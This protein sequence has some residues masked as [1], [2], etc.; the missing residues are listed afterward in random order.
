MSNTVKPKDNDTISSHMVAVP[1]GERLYLATLELSEQLFQMESNHDNLKNVHDEIRFYPVVAWEYRTSWWGRRNP[2][3]C[4]EVSPVILCG[5]DTGSP[6]PVVV[7]IRDRHPFDNEVLGV[8]VISDSELTE[9]G[10]DIAIDDAR[11]PKSL[12][13]SNAYKEALKRLEGYKNQL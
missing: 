5:L 4:P 10:I 1:L 2:E 3:E 12:T 13:R 9:Y 6:D 7:R 11:L 8:H